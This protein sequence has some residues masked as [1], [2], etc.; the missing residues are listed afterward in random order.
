MTYA[1]KPRKKKPTRPLVSKIKISELEAIKILQG[2]GYFFTSS[3]PKKD[4]FTTACSRR[5]GGKMELYAAVIV[6]MI[7]PARTAYGK[8]WVKFY[9]KKT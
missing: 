9:A 1:N 6:S 3:K 4:R 8:A 2:Y 7:V 5:A